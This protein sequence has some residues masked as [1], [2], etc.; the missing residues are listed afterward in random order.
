[1]SRIMKMLTADRDQSAVR[2][3]QSVIREGQIPYREMDEQTF[4]KKL[5]SPP[6]KKDRVWAALDDSESG[7]IIGHFDAGLQ[8]YFLTML[9]VESSC[10][11]QGIGTK[12]LGWLQK[13]MDDFA[14]QSGR[15]FP[16]TR[17]SFRSA[18][19]PHVSMEVSFYNPVNLVWDLPGTRHAYHPNAQGVMA[20]SP[21]HLFLKNAGF[22][23]FSMQNTY[24]L[25][26]TEY[27]FPMQR[28]QPYLDAMAS[29]GYTVEFYDPQVHTGMQELVDDLG[30]PIWNRQIPAE[31]NREGGPRPVLIVN[32]H[33]RVGGFAGPIVVEPSSRAFLLGLA[34]HSRCRGCG[35]ATVLFNRM[36][37]AFRDAGAT[38]MTFF[39][40]EDNPARNIYESAGSR[41]R[42]SWA[43]MRREYLR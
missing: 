37:E 38:Y 5:L 29:R 39:T 30:N 25:D 1:M 33:S 23:D 22:R 10:R 34:V 12:L 41:I 15:D 19:E 36:A 17:S 3:F 27:V 21:A 6:G 4:G 8:R 35:C 14:R 18:D 20:G 43:C 40:G 32:N 11:T 9:A 31:M 16:K 7:F 24:Y 42:M 28:L 26:L 2:I 13:Q